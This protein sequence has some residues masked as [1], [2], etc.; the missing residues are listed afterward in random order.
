MLTPPIKILIVE[1]EAIIALCLKMELKQA[2]YAV[3]PAAFTGEEAVIRA[4]EESPDVILMDIGLAG[5]IN[6]IEAAQQIRARSNVPIIFMTGYQEGDL[7][8]RAQTVNPVG[9]FIKPV[10][11]HNLKPVIDSVLTC[12]SE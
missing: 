10:S 3:G 9:Y 7:R 11:I 8:E 5:D 1:D 4:A 12:G 6:G 2:G